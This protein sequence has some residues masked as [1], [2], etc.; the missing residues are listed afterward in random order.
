MALENV[1]KFE[2]KI[3]GDEALQARLRELSDAFDG[4]KGD[5][6][7]VFDAVV[8][9]LAAEAGLP[10]T[11]DEALEY[12]AQKG[13]EEDISADDLKATA[14]GFDVCFVVGFG[15]VGADAEFMGSVVACAGIG[16]GWVAI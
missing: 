1:R 6:R 5:S 15:E 14:G 3:N 13:D 2:E 10:Y 8:A 16:A 12:V 11:Y 4:D 7:A 9:P